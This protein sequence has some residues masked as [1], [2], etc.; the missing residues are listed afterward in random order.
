[1]SAI[2][3]SD[4]EQAVLQDLYEAQTFKPYVYQ[5]EMFVMCRLGALVSA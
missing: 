4:Y 3:A 5:E 1:V 2:R